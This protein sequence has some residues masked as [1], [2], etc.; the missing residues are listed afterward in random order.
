VTD[1]LV[2]P[3]ARRVDDDTPYRTLA[4][5]D[6]LPLVVNVHVRRRLPPLEHAP[7]Q[8]ASRPFETLSLIEVPT[9]KD[10][11]PVS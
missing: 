3:P 5:T 2:T 11:D 9:A 6:A 4:V 8:T 1:F 7:D 10:A